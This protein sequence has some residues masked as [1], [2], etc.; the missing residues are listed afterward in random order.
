MGRDAAERTGWIQ[1]TPP[2]GV[3]GADIWREAQ[4]LPHCGGTTGTS[5][6]APYP[7]PVGKPDE[8]KP[9]FN[10]TT[11]RDIALELMQFGREFP[12]ILQAIWE[13]DPAEGSVQ[14]SNIYVTDA[15]HRG[16]L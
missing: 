6:D 15:Y 10:N 13:A 3:F 11:D 12:R 9:S 4:D 14:V 8:G 2:C 7:K 5:L 16:T 1:H